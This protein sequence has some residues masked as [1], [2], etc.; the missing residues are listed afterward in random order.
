MDN[1][2]NFFKTSLVLENVKFNITTINFLKEHFETLLS[3]NLIFS[4]KYND[5][6]DKLKFLNS[7][8]NSQL[9]SLITIERIF[10]LNEIDDNFIS[11]DNEETKNKVDMLESNAIIVEDEIKKLVQEYGFISIHET[12]N[13]IDKTIY[14]KHKMSL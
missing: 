4:N 9:K 3:S 7:E 5:T 12:L 11:I 2:S 10:L 1:D 13:V 8:S 6:M 14:E